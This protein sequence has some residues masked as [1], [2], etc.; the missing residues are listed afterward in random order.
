MNFQ[1]IYPTKKQRIEEVRKNLI[2]NPKT[3]QDAEKNKEINKQ[4]EKIEEVF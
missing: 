1:S 3:R 2:K 4:I